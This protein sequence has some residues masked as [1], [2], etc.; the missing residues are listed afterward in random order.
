M[1]NEQL[2]DILNGM[3]I[4]EFR[5]DIQVKSNVRWLL[6]NLAVRNK[7]HPNFKEA[8]NKIKELNKWNK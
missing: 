7:N 8:F 4:P 1:N 3:D 6:R 2:K 5:Q